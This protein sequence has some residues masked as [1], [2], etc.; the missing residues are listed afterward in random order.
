PAPETPQLVQEV[1]KRCLARDADERWQSARDLRA[2]LELAR[3]VPAPAPAIVKRNRPAPWLLAS[4]AL[5]VAAVLIV[6]LWPRRGF[7]AQGKLKKIAASGGPAQNICNISSDLG[8]TW[9]V[10]GDIVLAPWNRIALHRVSA[11]GGTPQQIT[12]LDAGR[13]ENSHRFPHF[14]PDGR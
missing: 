2:A 14:L 4:L 6:A 13:Q 10:A 1:V 8:A 7:F 9:N 12:T 5:G 11:A 3:V